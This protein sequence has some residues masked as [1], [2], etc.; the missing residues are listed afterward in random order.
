M[1]FASV[2]TYSRERFSLVIY[3]TCTFIINCTHRQLRS[4][5]SAMT[6]SVTQPYQACQ[7]H[8]PFVS[9]HLLEITRAYLI[10]TLTHLCRNHVTSHHSSSIGILVATSASKSIFHTTREVIQADGAHTSFGKYTLFSAYSTTAN[11]NMSSVAF[12]I[13][14]GNEDIKNWTLF[15]KFVARIHPTINRPVVTP[16]GYHAAFLVSRSLARSVPTR[17]GM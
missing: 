4:L 15:W 6:F 7:T 1:H 16:N 17:C 12:G 11:A 13:L 5:I 2:K 9:A 3:H 10:L 14:F 8:S